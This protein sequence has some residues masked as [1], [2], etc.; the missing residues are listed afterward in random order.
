MV[1]VEYVCDKC[2]KGKMVRDYNSPA[3]LP[4]PPQFMHECTSCN[5][6]EALRENYPTTGYREIMERQE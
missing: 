5:H 3:L 4:N 2:G 6:R 1:K